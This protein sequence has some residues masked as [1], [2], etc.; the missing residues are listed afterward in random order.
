MTLNLF[1]CSRCPRS[2]YRS[3][4]RQHQRRHLQQAGQRRQDQGGSGWRAQGGRHHKGGEEAGQRQRRKDQTAEENIQEGAEGGAGKGLHLDLVSNLGGEEEKKMLDQYI[5]M[6]DRK[7][8]ENSC[9]VTVLN[10]VWG[11]INKGVASY[12]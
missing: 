11:S 2:K 7:D 4:D 12:L 9:T 3:P 8:V 6:F 10:V 5:F 1:Y